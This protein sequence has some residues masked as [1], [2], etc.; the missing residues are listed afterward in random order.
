MKVSPLQ[1]NCHLAGIAAFP[2]HTVSCAWSMMKHQPPAAKLKQRS[3]P[4][5]KKPPLDVFCKLGSAGAKGK[6]WRSWETQ[7][8]LLT[9]AFPAQMLRLRA[10]LWMAWLLRSYQL[11]VFL[12]LVPLNFHPCSNVFERSLL[13]Q[14]HFANVRWERKGF[15]WNKV[16]SFLYG[17]HFHPPKTIPGRWLGGPAGIRVNSQGLGLE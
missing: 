5:S 6:G 14:R 9:Q 16:V 10:G 1:R 3:A 11:N 7:S 15:Q 12:F 17:E 8:D 13:P 2:A 4:L